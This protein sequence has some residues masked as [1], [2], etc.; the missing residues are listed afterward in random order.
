[1]LV[2]RALGASS[3]TTTARPHDVGDDF[4]DTTGVIGTALAGEVTVARLPVSG[5]ASGSRG[6]RCAKASLKRFD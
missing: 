6:V 2:A 5:A 3:T 1:L 4:V